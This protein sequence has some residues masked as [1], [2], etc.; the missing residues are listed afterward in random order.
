MNPRSGGWGCESPRSKRLAVTA[1]LPPTRP[2]GRGGG[3]ACP[4]STLRGG[5]K[6]R[7]GR[8]RATLSTPR[9]PGGKLPA[10]KPPGL[11]V[12]TLALATI[13][14]FA[15]R[16][17]APGGTATVAMTLPADDV[18]IAGA[19][20]RKVKATAAS[21]HL[22]RLTVISRQGG[23]TVNHGNVLGGETVRAITAKSPLHIVAAKA[24]QPGIANNPLRAFD[25]SRFRAVPSTTPVQP[26]T[27]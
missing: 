26:Q 18:G 19:V 7:C 1:T 25:G 10:M 8:L 11:S 20:C 2:K 15:Q 12:F 13:R 14:A 16:T 4:G 22:R 3:G 27:P 21:Y 5:A 6:G 9:P 17:E 24:R 23:M